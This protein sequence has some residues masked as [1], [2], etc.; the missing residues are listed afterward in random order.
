MDCDVIVYNISEDAEAIEEATWAVSGDISVFAGFMS[1]SQL[2]SVQ[3]E[4]I[5]WFFFFFF[6]FITALH[7]EIEY[8]AFPKMFILVS[9]LMTWAKTKPADPVSAV[10]TKSTWFY[11]Y[12]AEVTVTL[13]YY[14][15]YNY[16]LHSS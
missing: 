3:Y 6:F 15:S 2:C 12:V 4:M 14:N 7:S 9:T 16:R 11:T 8:F 13:F 5:V 1:T 10:P